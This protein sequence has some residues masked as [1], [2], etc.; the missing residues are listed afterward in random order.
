MSSIN[1]DMVSSI[2][3]SAGGFDAKYGDKMS[4]VLDIKYRKPTEF[5]GSATAS[6]VVATNSVGLRYLCI[7]NR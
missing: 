5:A 6:T 3:F 1:S 2:K 7:E 4:S